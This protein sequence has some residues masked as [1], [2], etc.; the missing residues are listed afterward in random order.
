MSVLPRF[1][2]R[3]SAALAIL[4]GLL[5]LACGQAASPPSQAGSTQTA[6]PQVP[7]PTPAPPCTVSVPEGSVTIT[8]N[9]TPTLLVDVDEPAT[10]CQAMR[11]AG[12]ID[13]QHGP[14]AVLLCEVHFPAGSTVVEAVR[15][16]SA[17]SP[18]GHQYCSSIRSKFFPS[19]APRP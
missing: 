13:A 19:P 5:L 12:F 1:E 14:A 17:D 9:N 8:V 10:I 7:G 6:T 2:G 4:G 11:N 16:A 3:T 18:L 15:A